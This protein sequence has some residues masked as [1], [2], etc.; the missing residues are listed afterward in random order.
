MLVFLEPTHRISIVWVLLKHPQQHKSKSQLPGEILSVLSDEQH[1]V[2]PLIHL[3]SD[4]SPESILQLG[5]CACYYSGQLRMR[6]LNIWNI[7]YVWHQ[8]MCANMVHIYSRISCAS[9]CV[10]Y[11]HFE[12]LFLDVLKLNDAPQKVQ[13][14]QSSTVCFVKGVMPPSEYEM[15]ITYCGNA[16]QMYCCFL[17]A[18]TCI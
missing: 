1:V 5:I 14:T 11:D 17:L 3:A 18:Y 16:C 9:P 7:S 15:I 12:C 10:A 2:P 6:G 8:G 13:C 4:W